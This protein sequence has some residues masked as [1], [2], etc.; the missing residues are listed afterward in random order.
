MKGGA[1]LENRQASLVIVRAS[2]LQ[3]PS[4]WNY[5]A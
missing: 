5:R 1:A 2:L 3:A 4:L